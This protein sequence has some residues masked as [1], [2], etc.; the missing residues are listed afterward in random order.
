MKDTPR[1]TLFNTF[2]VEGMTLR[3]HLAGQ[4][5]PAVL[6]KWPSVTEIG[7]AELAYI[8]ADAMLLIRN[9]DPADYGMEMDK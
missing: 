8:Q 2:A 4:A 1:T 7:A 9:I 6:A 3:D 5:L